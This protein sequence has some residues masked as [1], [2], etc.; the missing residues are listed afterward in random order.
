MLNFFYTCFS[1]SEQP[2]GAEAEAAGLLRG[3]VQR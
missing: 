2:A 1:L 3:A